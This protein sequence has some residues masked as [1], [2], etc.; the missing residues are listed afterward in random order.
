LILDTD[1]LTA[2]AG[3]QPGVIE[4]LS[5]AQTVALPVVVIGEYR[6]A[7]AQSRHMRVTIAGS[8]A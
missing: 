4:I 1:A 7:I 8:P 3:E 2:A 6:Y 5:R